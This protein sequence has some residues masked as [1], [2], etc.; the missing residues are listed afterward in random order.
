[1]LQTL[2]W[3]LFSFYLFLNFDVHVTIP[4]FNPT[5]CTCPLNKVK[6]L[7]PSWLM[8]KKIIESFTQHLF[9]D[10]WT[11]YFWTYYFQVGMWINS[12][13]IIS[14]PPCCAYPKIFTPWIKVETPMMN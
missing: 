1:M 3:I 2:R 6:T 8:G 5:S 13:S 4:K 10:S 14:I 11:Q 12:Q 9:D 7:K